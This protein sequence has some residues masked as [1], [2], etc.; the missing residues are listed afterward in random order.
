MA[1][2]FLPDYVGNLRAVSTAV[3]FNFS[4]GLLLINPRC[5]VSLEF[6][7]L[8]S[9]SLLFAL[10]S[11][12]EA[13]TGH[14]CLFWAYAAWDVCDY[15]QIMSVRQLYVWVWGS[16]RMLW[17]NDG[18]FESSKSS[19][20][21]RLSLCVCVQVMMLSF[22]GMHLLIVHDP[23]QVVHFLWKGHIWSLQLWLGFFFS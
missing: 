14:Q 20:Y 5:Q 19:G 3:I 9:Q 18:D 10:L 4:F 7:L 1:C 23:T 12:F 2:F 15:L 8:H 16:G 21:F 6:I 11:P 13:V 17:P 22:S